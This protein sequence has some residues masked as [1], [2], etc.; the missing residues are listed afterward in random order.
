LHLNQIT[1]TL[2]FSFARIVQPVLE[3]QV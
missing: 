1:M 2:L 3:Q